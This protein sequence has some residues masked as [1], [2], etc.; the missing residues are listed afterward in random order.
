[1]QTGK[2]KTA[3]LAASK[4]SENSNTADAEAIT[5][6]IA[7]QLEHARTNK[8]LSSFSCDGISA[9]TGKRNGVDTRLRAKNKA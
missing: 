6:A 2:A 4:L 5:N 1:M 3:F 8:K 9:I 7:A